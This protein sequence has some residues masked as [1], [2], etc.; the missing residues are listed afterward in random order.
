MENYTYPIP[1]N[2]PADDSLQW[3]ASYIWLEIEQLVF[4][5]ILCSNVVFLLIRSCVKHKLQLD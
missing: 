2:Y 1:E 4:I 5:S 3:E